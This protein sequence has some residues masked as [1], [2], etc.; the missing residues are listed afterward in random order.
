VSIFATISDPDGVANAE[1]IYLLENEFGGS[2]PLAY[3]AGT[4]SG[5][6]PAQ[7]E[8]CN[9]TF[10]VYAIDGLGHGNSAGNFTYTVIAVDDNEGPEIS[11][12][13]SPE[14][15][16]QNQN[17]IVAAII[18]DPSGVD[19]AYILY[20]L[21]GG[22]FGQMSM[23]LSGLVWTGIIPALPVGTNV[24]FGVHAKDSLGNWNVE[25]NFSY[26]VRFSSEATTTTTNAW[27]NT[28]GIFYEIVDLIVS[29]IALVS[30]GVI[31]VIVIV[32]IVRARNSQR[33]ASWE[34]QF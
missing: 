21:D 18:E 16:S 10:W 1:L 9:V 24:T 6:I 3:E 2:I 27:G 30:G 23:S 13:F 22:S 12:T 34:S 28:D 31:F 29:N 20:Y 11:V 33:Y 8:G 26:V 25:G 14:N 7:P 19:E 15:P 5:E 17:V 4:W 32:V